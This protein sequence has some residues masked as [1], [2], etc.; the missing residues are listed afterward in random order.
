MGAPPAPPA[1]GPPPSPGS[2]PRPPPGT[3][4]ACGAGAAAAPPA[5]GSG[6]PGCRPLPS[7][8]PRGRPRPLARSSRAVRGGSWRAPSRRPPPPPPALAAGTPRGCRLWPVASRGWQP[9]NPCN[10]GAKLIVRAELRAAHPLRARQPPRPQAET[11]GRS[12]GRGAGSLPGL[13]WW[14]LCPLQRAEG[15]PKGTC[16]WEMQAGVLIPVTVPAMP[17]CFN[18]EQVHLSLSLISAAGHGLWLKAWLAFSDAVLRKI[19]A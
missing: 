5:A 2:P 8:A 14:L 16:R 12:Q 3:G 10:D 11:H 7:R 4:A 15:S 19:K 6:G 9:P 1:E 13:R 17:R 18:V